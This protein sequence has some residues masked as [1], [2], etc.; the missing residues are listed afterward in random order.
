MDTDLFSDALAPALRKQTKRAALTEALLRQLAAQ[1][2]TLEQ[3]ADKRVM[4]RSA[5]TL[6]R[7]ARK[8]G[9]VFSDYAPRKMREPAE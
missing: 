4:C 7:H 2:L 6:K 3:C 8:F 5:T 9:I 1:G